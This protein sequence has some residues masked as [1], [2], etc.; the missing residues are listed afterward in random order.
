MGFD[1]LRWKQTGREY[2]RGSAPPMGSWEWVGVADMFNP[3]DVDPRYRPTATS[4]IGDFFETSFTDI[5]AANRWMKYLK[6]TIEENRKL[7]GG[8]AVSD[9]ELNEFNSFYEKEWKTYADKNSLWTKA[10]DP[11]KKAELDRLLVKSREMHDRF[12][13]KG[14]SP[15]PV[16]YMAELTLMLRSLPRSMLAIEMRAKL[17]A[18]IKCG[19]KLAGEN[20]TVWQWVLLDDD[21]PLKKAIDDARKMSAILKK[22]RNKNEVYA[23]GSP[24][25]DEFVRRLT[26]I[27][28]EASVLYGVSEVRTTAVHEG[29]DVAVNRAD[30]TKTDITKLLILAGLGYLGIR[31]LTHSKTTVVVQ[32]QPS[33][34]P[35][36][37]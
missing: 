14:M 30:E 4:G 12:V 37:P 10:T 29:A 7:H 16:P 3:Q 24:V 27:Y 9:A 34:S 25:Y 8:K 22:T 35:R 15:V 33:P 31:W 1:I 36:H 19:K 20:T 18:A 17:E 2:G 5:D 21:K 13:K 32:G 28:T 6:R 26:R 11:D 23:I